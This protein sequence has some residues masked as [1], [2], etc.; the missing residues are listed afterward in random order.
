MVNVDT[1]TSSHML[2]KKL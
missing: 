1:V 2:Y